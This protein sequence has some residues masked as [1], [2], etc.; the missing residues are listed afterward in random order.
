IKEMEKGLLE[1]QDSL[2]AFHDTKGNANYSDEDM[3]TIDK[4]NAEIRH[5]EKLLGVLRESERNMAKGSDDGGRMLPAHAGK[6]NG[7][8]A[9]SSPRPFAVPA[10]KLDPVELLIRAGTSMIIAQ[11]QR[12][13]VD[14][15][16][17]M[18]YG[19]DEATKAVTEWQTK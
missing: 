4:T 16:R 11:R 12:Q 15:V 14:E 6:P 8:T 13:P 18:I 1:K 2:A 19:D 3:E 7:S 10:K 9:S 17:R 5:D